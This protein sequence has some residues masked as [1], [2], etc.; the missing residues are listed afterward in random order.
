[1]VLI[2]G[3]ANI[4]SVRHGTTGEAIKDIFDIHFPNAG[5]VADLT[6]GKGGF[7]SKLGSSG[8]PPNY[9]Q[10]IG[11]DIDVS[12]KAQIKSD[13]RLV[14]LQTQSVDVAVFDPPFIFTP[15]IRGLVGA[16]RFFL[17]SE[18]ATDG[19]FYSG[20]KS[21]SR[22]LAPR[23]AEDLRV[24]TLLVMIEMRRIA[25]MGC[26]LKGQ[27]LITSKHPNWWTYQVI[28]H[29]HKLWGLEPE[30]ELIQI[31]PAARMVDPRWKR[32]YHFR[33][34]HAYYLVYKWD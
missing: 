29:G 11:L 20:S 32:Q 30:D 21:D 31:S 9:I 26:I 4:G 25:R 24:Q 16:K 6:W 13:Y 33:R 10:V 3:Y 2:N 19:R 12:G 8:L 1:V 18:A 17:G 34:H 22:I 15:G 7:W 14:P 5:G 28:D 27:N 23:N